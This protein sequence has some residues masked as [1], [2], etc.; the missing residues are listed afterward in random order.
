MREDDGSFLASAYHPQLGPAKVSG[1]LR[2]GSQSLI[3]EGG[4]R[5]VDL[6]LRGLEVKAGGASGRLVFF[7]HPSFP[8]VSVF[9]SDR[10]ILRAPELLDLPDLGV[11]ASSIR[12][13]RRLAWTVSLALV[14]AL[15]AGAA[16]LFLAKDAIV[17]AV[18]RQ[19]PPEWEVKLGETVIREL[20]AGGRPIEDA[21]TRAALDRLMQPLVDAIVDRPYPFRFHL[22]DDGSINAFAL[23]GG[24][25]AIHSGLI[26]AAEKPEEVL[27]V[28]AHEIA[29]VTR[30]HGLQ[31]IVGSLGLVLILQSLVGD[32]GGLTAVLQEQSGLLLRLKFS[33]D[34]ERDADAVGWDYLLR[35]RIDPRGM[36]DLFQKIL[37]EEARGGPGAEGVLAALSTH[38]GAEERIRTLERRWEALAEK[39]DFIRQDEAFR[40]LQE[41][42]RRRIV[43]RKG[44]ENR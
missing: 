31:Q 21:E 4:P 36:R 41:L 42:V 29:H 26:L 12:S 2:V 19:V 17:G 34:F 22:L 23:P 40:A 1:T 20:L 15:G 14:L 8:G 43:E 5:R 3:F 27:G 33:R 18:V 28:V 10:G 9:T 25:V 38:P 7:S 6:P 37:E 30:Q 11:Q 39:P 13:R 35:A 44:V 24:P 32:V 16:G